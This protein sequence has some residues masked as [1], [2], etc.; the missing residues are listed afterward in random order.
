MQR[1]K[2]YVIFFTVIK[3]PCYIPCNKNMQWL[4]CCVTFFSIKKEGKECQGVSWNAISHPL[5]WKYAVIRMLSHIPIELCL[6][7]SFHDLRQLFPGSQTTAID[8]DSIAVVKVDEVYLEAGDAYGYAVQRC[9]RCE[10]PGRDITK[11]FD[12]AQFRR[13][14]YDGV[15]APVQAVYMRLPA[16]STTL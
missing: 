1:L 16:S 6:N 8:D 3:M 15:V 12:F 11:S 2:Y 14:F 10:F 13:H 5:H 9:L 4:E 7:T